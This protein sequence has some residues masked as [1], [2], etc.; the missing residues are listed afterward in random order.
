M[1]LQPSTIELLSRLDAFSANR[2]SRRDDL[3]IL[4]E[5][6]A[7]SGKTA[8]LDDLSFQGKFVSKCHG[9]MSRIGP[10]GNGYD[11]LAAELATNLDKAKILL[12]SLLESST[13]EVRR[14]FEMTYLSMTPNAFR[15]L[16]ALFYDL[17]WYKNWH[18]DKARGR[19]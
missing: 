13:S 5:L 4:I 19:N 3:G 12:I 9:I 2:L 8:T 14:H 18:L 1:G 15:N 11:K 16:L 6:A 17:S 10:E 7:Q